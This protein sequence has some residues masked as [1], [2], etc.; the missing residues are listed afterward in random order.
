MTVTSPVTAGLEALATAGRSV[1]LGRARAV[2][3]GTTEAVVPE[4]EASARQEA[5]A[6]VLVLEEPDAAARR[7]ASVLGRCRAVTLVLPEHP[8]EAEALV[9][10]AAAGL[11]ERRSPVA[12]VRLIGDDSPVCRAVA[13]ALHRTAAVPVGTT[14][15]GTGSLTASLSLAA[16]LAEGEG[17]RLV[18][19]VSAHGPAVLAVVDQADLRGGA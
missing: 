13:E 6:V 3:V 2:L 19:A 7:G 11:L 16:V 14:A 15:H 4:G 5:G 10:K 9:A 18:A 1:A 17:T 8:G 12:E